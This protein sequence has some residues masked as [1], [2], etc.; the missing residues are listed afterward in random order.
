M[1]RLFKDGI[2]GRVGS[3]SGQTEEIEAA[4]KNI[5]PKP[6]TG[7]HSLLQLWQFTKLTLG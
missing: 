2:K 4:L 7:W 3:P 1:L 6:Y 5:L